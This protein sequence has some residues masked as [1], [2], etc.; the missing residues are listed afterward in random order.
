MSKER[1]R[2]KLTITKLNAMQKGDEIWDQVESGLLVR[3]GARGNSFLYSFTTLQGV[4]RKMAIGIVSLDQARGMAAKWRDMVREGKDPAEVLEVERN[5]KPETT[6]D[7]LEARWEIEAK[8]SEEFWQQ[9]R[10][11]HGDIVNDGSGESDRAFVNMKSETIVKYRCYW[12]QIKKKYGGDKKVSSFTIADLQIFH[13]EL[14]IKRPREAGEKKGPMRGGKTQANRIIG[15]LLSLFGAS[16][17]WGLMEEAFD[18]RVSVLAKKICRNREKSSDLFLE[19]EHQPAFEAQLKKLRLLGALKPGKRDTRRMKEF[20]A[21]ADLI[22]LLRAQGNRIGEFMRAR[23]SWIDWSKQIKILRLQDS[24]T[25]AIDVEL[26]EAA[27]IILKRLCEEWHASGG[28]PGDENDWVIRSYRKAGHPL[29]NPYKGWKRFLQDAGL[30]E[31]LVPHSL[32]H[33]MATFAIGEGGASMEQAAAMLSHKNHKTTA[34]YAH[35]I[36]KSV[37]NVI[38][39]TNEAMRQMAEPQQQETIADDNIP[40]YLKVERDHLKKLQEAATS[41]TP[42]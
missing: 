30:P 37:V 25:G 36:K 26:G 12:K 19:E 9:R 14:S 17:L 23:L 40:S 24:K 35:R 15:F 38:N 11:A 3:A 7:D 13:D 29:R 6:L 20:R 31:N 10:N 4:R 33:T 2:E 28:K 5:K 8:K 34:R 27:I 39:Q 21:R 32:R 41:S 18:A 1:T 42:H 22:E 16:V